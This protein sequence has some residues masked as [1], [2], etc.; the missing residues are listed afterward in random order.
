MTEP[1]LDEDRGLMAAHLAGDRDAFNELV[2]RHRQR[3]WAVA[4]R[5]LGDPEEAADA[6]QDACISALR[7]AAS[8]RGDSKVS[9]WLHRIVVNACLDRARRQAV[10]ATVPLPDEPIADERDVLGDRE[11]A[12]EV[13]QALAA[14]PA[15]QR[16]ALVLV[17][18]EGLSVDEAAGL[19][20]VPG[21]TVKSRCFRGR[22]RLAVSLGHLRNPVPDGAVPPRGGPPP[23]GQDKDHHQPVEGGRG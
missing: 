19:L 16:I 20:G 9:T 23:S 4:L 10:R 7:A 6:V 21:G 1:E 12:L 3:M 22:A 5:T 8:F 13:Q 18:L 11:T 2:R 15:D 17:D 14:L